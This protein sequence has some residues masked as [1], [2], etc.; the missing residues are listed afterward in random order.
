MSY[1]G[2][3]PLWRF[4][5]TAVLH[6]QFMVIPVFCKTFVFL[7]CY[8]LNHNLISDEIMIDICLYFII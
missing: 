6:L 7:H 1:I 3:W 5:K 4:R 2:V 8:K